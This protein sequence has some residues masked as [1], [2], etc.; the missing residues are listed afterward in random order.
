MDLRRQLRRECEQFGRGRGG[1]D[2]PRAALFG[3]GRDGRGVGFISRGAGV[4][5]LRNGYSAL[6]T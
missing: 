5:R 3:D 6:R 4:V 2:F 1:E